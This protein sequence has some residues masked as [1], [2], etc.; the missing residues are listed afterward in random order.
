MTPGSG[1]QGSQSQYLHTIVTVAA[2]QDF[3]DLSEASACGL[4]LVGQFDLSHARNGAAIDTH[5]VWMRLM[6]LSGDDLKSPNV[7]TEFRTTQQVGR[8][9]VIQVA[10]DRRLVDFM[11]R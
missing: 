11:F 7:I 5:K 6:L 8:D 3:C 1:I 2:E 4:A 10:E 9:H